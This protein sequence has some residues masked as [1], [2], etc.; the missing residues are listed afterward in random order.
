MD[1]LKLTYKDSSF[2]LE[3]ASGIV[4]WSGVYDT[5]PEVLEFARG[6]VSSFQGCYLVVEEGLE[7]RFYEDKKAR[8]VF[9]FNGR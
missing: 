8:D 9:Y 5:M 3:S 1:N 2:A 7:N 4:L 6:Y